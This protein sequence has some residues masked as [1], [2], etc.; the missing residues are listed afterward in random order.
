M[1]RAKSLARELPSVAL[2]GV[3]TP[4]VF[5]D[6]VEGLVE[7]ELCR[8]SVHR[9][10]GALFFEQIFSQFFPAGGY[11]RWCKYDSAQP[12][13]CRFFSYFDSFRVPGARHFTSNAPAAVILTR[14]FTGT[15][16]ILDC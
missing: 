7:F 10:G 6:E 5:G 11:V 1:A 3:D 2:L 4:F 16:N 8:F 13:F 12:V 14:K 15:S 9:Q